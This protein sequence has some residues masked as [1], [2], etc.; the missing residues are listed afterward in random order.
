MN[1][2]I[3]RSGGASLALYVMGALMMAWVLPVWAA[4]FDCAKAQT[5]V[6]RLICAD[7]QL[8]RLD[9]E[10][11][12]SYKVALQDQAN[13]EAIKQAQRHW[14][15]ERNACSDA[16]CVKT[17]YKRR[18]Q[19]IQKTPPSDTQRK[20]SG[21]ADG[22]KMTVPRYKLLQEEPY[23]PLSEICEEFTAMINTF[24]PEEPLMRCEQKLHP[25]FP[26][27]KSIELQ[28]L[29]DKDNFKYFTAIADLATRE[30]MRRGYAS[31]RTDEELKRLFDEKERLGGYR[32][33]LLTT[34]RFIKNKTVTMLV[35]ERRADCRLKHAAMD[36]ARRIAY[37][38]DAKTESVA[39]YLF[40]FQSIFTY[41]GD[42]RE[43]DGLLFSNWNEAELPTSSGKSGGIWV[44]QIDSSDG[45]SS[46][47]CTIVYSGKH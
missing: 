28:L 18:L 24:G 40:P 29:P 6:E 31:Y 32:Y 37:E 23:E 14:V 41:E 47:I 1:I 44:R 11:A 4:S 26:N 7:P 39:R 16:D 42:N 22:R 34:D 13:A 20:V 45:L 33:Y 3:K 21:N 46:H 12:A 15:R 8:S 19:A 5:R 9:E 2:K 30:V 27:F 36:S 25:A 10:M 38:W 17:I 35:Q 43:D